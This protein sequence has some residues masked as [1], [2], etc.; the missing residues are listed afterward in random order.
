MV[1]GAGRTEPVS[2]PSEAGGDG[3]DH[4]T[5]TIRAAITAAESRPW[6]QAASRRDRKRLSRR[7][8]DAAERDVTQRGYLRCSRV[9]LLPIRGVNRSP[10]IWTSEKVQ[11]RCRLRSVSHIFLGQFLDRPS[12]IAKFTHFSTL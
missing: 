7:A 4:R 8:W 12:V 5:S 6:E 2:E 3:T 1:G 10:R 9:Q 11:F